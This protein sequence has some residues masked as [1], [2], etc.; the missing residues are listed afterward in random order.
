MRVVI[1]N[2]RFLFRFGADRVLMLLAQHLKRLGHIVVLLG[3]H[4]DDDSRSLFAPGVVTV[5]GGSDYLG[6]NEHT[7]DWLRAHW[8]R[9]F[10]AGA[11]PELA[12]VGGW[13]FYAA[14]PLLRERCEVMVVDYGAVPLDGYSRGEVTIQHKLRTLR[15]RHLASA[16]VVVAISRFIAETQSRKDAGDQAPV[17]TLL[18]GADH[19]EHGV[20]RGAEAGGDRRATTVERL[21]RDGRRTLLCLGRWEPGCYKNSDAALRVLRGIRAR[22]PE[23]VLLV[24]AGPSD[25]AVPPDLA[26]WIVPIGFPGDEEL[27]DIMRQVDV[28]LSVSLWEGFNLPLAEMQWLGRPALAFDIGAHPEVIID[29]WYLCRDETDMATKAVELLAPGTH[30]ATLPPDALTTFR[31]RFSWDRVYREFRELIGELMGR[32]AVRSTLRLIIDVTCSVRDPANSG[33]IRVTRRLA[34]TL[35]ELADPLFV[36]WDAAA[37]GYVLPREEEFHQLGQFTG[38]VKPSSGHFSPSN[39]RIGLGEAL[40]NMTGSG[41]VWLLLTETIPAPQVRGALDFARAHNVRVAAI[42]YD[43]IP[44]LYPE[45]CPDP[46]IRDNHGAYIRSLADCDLV[47]PISKFSARCL[48]DCWHE[49]GMSG[50]EVRPNVLPGEFGVSERALERSGAKPEEVQILYVSTLEPRKNHLTLVKACRLLDERFP[51]TKWTLTLVG[52]KYAG[53]FDLADAIVAMARQDPRIR[54]PGIVDDATLARLYREATFTVYPSL[55]E[56]FGMPIM[57]SLWHGRPCVCSEKGVMAELAVGGGCLTTDVTDER[58]LCEA[59]GRLATDRELRRRLEA[60]AV[61]RPIRTWEQYGVDLVSA[62][63]SIGGQGDRPEPRA[64]AGR[65]HSVRAWFE[66]LYPGC[67][68]G[69]WQQNESERLALTAVL[70]R[71]RPRC[72]IEVGTYR[73]GSLSLIRQYSD[74]VF[75]IDIDPEV[76][77]RYRHFGNVSF[78]AGPSAVVLPILLTELDAAGIPVEFVLIDADHSEA[79]IRRD[80]EC[81]LDYVPKAPLFV[82]LHDSFNPECRRGMLAAS[83]PRSPYVSWVDIDFVPGRI[84]EHGGGSHGEMWGGLAL[85]YLTPVPR[86]GELTVAASAQMMFEKLRDLQYPR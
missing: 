29:P 49:I 66:I 42:F 75:S 23:S 34:R 64:P 1:C 73:G 35:Q 17:R 30:G 16:S 83:W 13:P 4:F 62:L 57:E 80:I 48:Q 43:A 45:L 54:W 77:E 24:L 68:L 10:P 38:P 22:V 72:S 44:V 27:R 5:P 6:L 28:G 20:W 26:G 63:A 21:K 11:G 19:I 32:E 47:L 2:E 55:V 52:N 84:I 37:G 59:I 56:G 61:A 81:L 15:Q 67:L 7:A 46:S 8:E 70:A 41:P 51:G 79:G 9:L 33:V 14:L 39:G 78:L 85:A 69:A 36:V 53:A 3:N 58:A 31:G 82:T 12:I 74:V 76:A 60:E 71:H 40:P 50:C 18:L 65:T 86:R 25:V